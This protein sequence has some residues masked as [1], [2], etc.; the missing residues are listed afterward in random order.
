MEERNH[1]S[2]NTVR[3]DP[4]R[5]KGC[6]LC[7]GVCPNGLFEP[8]AADKEPNALGFVPVDMVWPEYCI[9]CM[10]CVVV[11]PDDAFDVPENPQPNW[12][13]QV[14]GLSRRFHRF[15]GAP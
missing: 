4:E 12:Q 13:G 14:F 9:N 2:L 15:W 6:E 11:C 8:A 1:Q 3:L 5:C 7:L 10:R